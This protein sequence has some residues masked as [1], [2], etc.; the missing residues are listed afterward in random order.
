MKAKSIIYL[1]KTLRLSGKINIKTTIP[2]NFIKIYCEPCYGIYLVKTKIVK[3]IRNNH[4]PI[5]LVIDL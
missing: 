4:F 3:L 2:Y 1:V 5:F